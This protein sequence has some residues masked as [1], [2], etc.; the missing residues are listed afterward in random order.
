MRFPHGTF[1]REVTI[2]VT[3]LAPAVAMAQTEGEPLLPPVAAAEGGN[4]A[5]PQEDL[6]VLTRAPLH[7][8]FATPVEQDPQPGQ[9][10]DAAPPEPIE[11]LPP[12]VKPEGDNVEWIPGYWAWDEE[13]ER[14]IWISGVW[15]S[16]PPGREWVP[17]YWAEADGG[18]RWVSGYWGATAPS[19]DQ[20]A[21][22]VYD[23]ARQAEAYVAPPPESLDVGPI[24]PQP[25]DRHFWVPGCWIGGDAGYRWRP[26]Y[27]YPYQQN[28]V[29]VPDHYVWTPAG[30]V[31]VPGYW[32]YTLQ[33]RGM[34]FAPVYFRRPLFLQPRYVYRPYY[35]LDIAR[36]A[37]HLFVHPTGRY[38][39][40]GDYYGTR[41]ASFGYRPWFQ[42][43]FGYYGL[44]SH[45]HRHR[46]AYDPLLAY[47]APHF[48]RRG[49]DYV[50]RL[51]GWHR[52]YDRHADHRPPRT[53][54]QAA[55]A[56]QSS[57]PRSEYKHV[58]A[59]TVD[60]VRHARRDGQR[61]VVELDRG[62]REMNERMRRRVEAA[63][64][65]AR[66]RRRMELSSAKPR[67]IEREQR[68]PRI[69][70]GDESARPERTAPRGRD[71]GDGPDRRR[72]AI[73]SSPPDESREQYRRAVERARELAR[74]ARQEDRRRATVRPPRGIGDDG[75]RQSA[76]RESITREQERSRALA[77]SRAL[78]SRQRMLRFDSSEAA[79]ARDRAIERLQS[80]REMQP[81]RETPPTS[82]SRL[83]A[84]RERTRQQALESARQAQDAIRARQRSLEAARRAATNRRSIELSRERAGAVGRT[85]AGDRPPFDGRGGREAVTRPQFERPRP[86][87]QRSSPQI[88]PRQRQ[89]QPRQ[90]APQIQPRQQRVQPRAITPQ[91]SRAPSRSPGRAAEGTSRPTPGRANYKAR[92]WQSG[93]SPAAAKRQR[94]PQPQVKRAAPAGGNPGRGKGSG[95]A[96]R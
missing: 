5:D 38:Y 71:A 10:I 35:P 84:D 90:R 72:D 52:Y 73:T 31:F 23:A 39:C 33:A 74:N 58:L 60:D 47:Y 86:Q 9:L 61:R 64:D 27:W 79:R 37:L 4:A 1:V 93:R 66:A 65:V 89:T 92:L 91:R 22:S 56:A 50:D 34:C 25:S 68:P 16:L 6:E 75:P 55:T 85:R 41:Y 81:G 62:D 14:Y 20:V 3:S 67:P 40:Y 30:S 77:E 63:R 53:F 43:H 94:G 24:S 19:G 51:R 54:K 82:R 88:Q 21:R 78:Q 80:R 87:V 17:G 12:E 49:I 44:R 36:L 29:W 15:R 2:L 13:E 8:A 76:R 83:G 7:E 95:K 42:F 46:H 96:K 70:G 57:R 18:Y 69:T 26:G 48:H 32:D 28:W 11:E 45:H 59:R